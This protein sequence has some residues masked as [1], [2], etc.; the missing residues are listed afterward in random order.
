M[1]TNSCVVYSQPM[2]LILFEREEIDTPLYSE[3]TRT[4]HI[5]DV[6]KLKAGDTFRAGVINVSEGY[7]TITDVRP[8]LQ[9]KYT[10][11]NEQ[12]GTSP[13]SVL[14]GMVRPIQVRRILKDLATL[15]VGEIH[16]VP[17]VLGEKSYLQ[18]D[19]WTSAV[20]RRYLVDGSQ[21]G[22]SAWIPQVL[23][24]GNLR[25]ALSS[26][27][28]KK[29][30]LFDTSPSAV[31]LNECTFSGGE[32]CMAIG[33]ERGWVDSE[34]TLFQKAGFRCVSFGKR[35]LRSETA[36]VVAAAFVLLKL[37]RL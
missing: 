18:S 29:G 8:Y 36:A 22:A 21:Q 35:I 34:I 14:L 17:T 23:V 19:I 12:P 33:P 9:T 16:F 31:R 24:H 27:S 5:L 11:E 1:Y 26:V 37:D 32:P 30:Y 3:D 20:F 10:A 4:R 7:C 28:K 15:G 25:E 13:V 6:L 2:N